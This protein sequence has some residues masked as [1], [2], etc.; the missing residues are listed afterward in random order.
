MESHLSRNVAFSKL[1]MIIEN[2][3]HDPAGHAL[4]FVGTCMKQ[5]PTIATPKPTVQVEYFPNEMERTLIE[6]PRIFFYG[7]RIDNQRNP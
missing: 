7:E 6:L 5:V 2:R 1:K 3:P 4:D